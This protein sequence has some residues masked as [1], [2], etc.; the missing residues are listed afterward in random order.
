MYNNDEIAQEAVK[1]ATQWQNRANALQTPPEKARHAKLARLFTN[2]KDKVILTQLIDQSFRSTDFRRVANQIH[3]LLTRH[4]IPTFF[5]PPEKILMLLFMHAGRFLPRLTVPRVIDKM[6]QDSSH[7][8]IS[9]EPHVLGT[10]L[11]DKK[12]KGLRININHIG[13]EVLGEQE[14]LSRLNMYIDDL[15]NP[16]IEYVSV[17]ISTIFSQLNPL[18]FDH[19]VSILTERLTQLY[20]SADSHKYERHDGTQVS[21]F[22]NLDMEAYR[23]LEMT[24][25]AFIR[26]LEQD[27]FKH[28]FAGM[29]LQAYLPDSYPILQDITAWARKRVDAGG[30]PVKIRIVKGANMEMECFESAVFDWPL[31]PF[32]TKLETDANWKRMVEFA[33]QPE[34]IK[35]VRLGVASHNLLDLAYAYRVGQDNGVADYYTFEMIEGMANHVRRT[36]QETGQQLIVYVPVADKDQ[37]LNAIAYLIRRLDENTGPQNFLRHLNRLR[38]RS[39]SWDFLTRHFLSSLKLKA[40]PAKNPHRTQNRISETFPEKMGTYHENEFKNE[41]NTDW[42][43]AANRRWAED[44]RRRWKIN[45][46]NSPLEIPLVIC[47]KEIFQSRRKRD[48]HDPSQINPAVLVAKSALANSKDIDRAAATA[49]E[50]PDGWRQK[51]HRQR[52]RVL[53]KV[54]MELR[55]ARG[56]LIGAAAANTGKVFTEA[57]V[58]ISEAIDFAEYYPHSAETF[59]RSDSVRSHGK[60]VGV[61]ISPW[62]FPI[63]IPCGGIVASLAAG[64]TVIFKPSSDALL[65][66]WQLCQCFWRAGVSPNVLQFVPCSSAGTAQKLTSHPDVD[67]II[68]TGGTQTGLAILNQRPE[69]FLA[70]ET[71]GKNATIVTAMSDRDQAIKNVIYS[72][73]GNSGQ[74][75]SATSLLIL[76]PEVYRDAGFKKQLVDA[77]RSFGTGSA[78][79]FANQMGPLIRPP[80]P[81][82]KK[83]LT[84]L[85]PGESWALKPQTVDKNPLM[86]TPGIKWGVRPNSTTHLTEFFGPLL[87]VMPA[88]NLDHAVHLVNQTGYGLTSGLESLDPRE[89]RSWKKGVKAGNLYINRGTTGAVVLRQP[90]GGMG[91]SAIGMGM[92]TGGPKYVAQFM[93][94]EEIRPPAS[95]PLQN[96]HPLLKLAQQWQQK[97]DWDGFEDIAADMKKSIRAIKSYLYYAEREFGREMDY[98]HLRG[99]D[100]ILR[101]L[102]AGTVV[103]RLHEDDSLFETLARIAAV[104]ISGCRLRISCPK[105][106]NNRVTAFLHAGEGRRL[107]G[108]DPH[109][110]EPDN[111]L[112]KIIPEVDRIR[113]AA[114]ERVPEA[115]YSVAAE[116]G[117][118]I[119]RA[120][121]MQD[122][123][124][125]LLHYYRQQSICDNYHRYG[126]LGERALY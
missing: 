23:D 63:A 120:P 97:L 124:I 6:R 2:P 89:Q 105:G 95:G 7:L 39:R 46:S 86:W 36:I 25:A 43:L 78:W 103:V 112:V 126:N 54:A 32:D 28:T 80:E 110:Y 87:G 42:S 98:F 50:D 106:L 99:Q 85:E 9:G 52:H 47:G 38:T 19:C 5:S 74:K 21:K 68:L 94:F 51:T 70:G 125:E 16:A 91:K 96:S 108:E 122:G 104:K 56:D 37:F 33:M 76:E 93:E 30:N 53:S 61:V 66:G 60:G 82:L 31:A 62:N 59:L 45:P 48:V 69:V 22:V 8:I 29:A 119:A 10:F 73:F 12:N 114:P 15:K 77:A 116:T 101:Y 83:A 72:A 49:R 26:T 57:D 121:V 58:E 44:I 79:D 11:Q 35:A 115:V 13:E 24:A 71:G 109:F 84:A 14:A 67:F 81:D 117:F 27:E 100:N 1:L 40:Q 64:N 41:P 34:N 118:Y 90:F 107:I 92:K 17:K 65:V 88:D 20:R 102:P 55:K 113:Y 3:Y 75:C 123:R 111:D 4:G 18:A